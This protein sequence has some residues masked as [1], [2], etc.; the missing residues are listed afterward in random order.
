[1]KIVEKISQTRGNRDLSVLNLIS[2]DDLSDADLSL[3][4]DLTA[5]FLKSPA[6]KLDLLRGKT[7]IGAFLEN[8]TRTRASFEL[9]GKKLGA[10][11]VFISASGSSVA[12]GESLLDTLQT[13][14]A[15]R[16]DAIILR[17]QFS[18]APKQFANSVCAPLISAGDG[19]REH[20]SQALL[21][22]FVLREN[23]GENLAGKEILIVGDLRH[24]RVF[25]SLVRLLPRLK[26][27]I[28]I[29]APE[30]LLPPAAEKLPVEIFTD[31]K[32]TA[33]GVDAI[34][35][36]RVQS[37]RGASGFV[38]TLKDYSTF[39]GIKK[40]TLDG[41]GRETILLDAGPVIRDIG[42]SHDL[43]TDPRSKILQQIETGVAL[44]K[45]LLYLTVNRFDGKVKDFARG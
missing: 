24:S 16:A 36:I 31:L 42:V 26:M 1:M 30:T 33:R 40:E 11:T 17:T 14:D 20:P 32:T 15:M 37:E 21:D 38:S 12:K 25:G 9:A 43:M 19:C 27:K 4:F 2:I 5:Q 45:S 35:N 41:T 3:I 44:R 29:C 6:E 34:Y 10:D 7:I 18:F 39:F 22:A 28:R 8:S 13:L 23:F